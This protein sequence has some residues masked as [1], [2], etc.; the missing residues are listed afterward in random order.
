MA[1]IEATELCPCGSG[2]SFAACH[3]PRVRKPV[4]PETTETIR[5]KVI[6]E[7]DPDTRAVFIYEGDGT[8]VM[9]GYE[10][11]LSMNCGQCNSPLIRGLN[12]TQISGIVL[13]CKACGAFNEA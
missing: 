1:L 7:P 5:L 6:P 11:G 3:G 10:T 13:R 9:S 8:V 4:V 12:R 2:K